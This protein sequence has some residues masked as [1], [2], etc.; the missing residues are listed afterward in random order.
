MSTRDM[1]TQ[2]QLYEIA[3]NISPPIT[4]KSNKTAIANMMQYLERL[5]DAKEWVNTLINMSD[6]ELR[7][8]LTTHAAALYRTNI[9]HGKTGT[10]A[11]VGLLAFIQAQVKALKDAGDLPD[12]DSVRVDIDLTDVEIGE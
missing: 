11:N 2:Q 5:R 12:D 6:N 3:K 9:E 4:A 10:K 7:E 8:E 1:K